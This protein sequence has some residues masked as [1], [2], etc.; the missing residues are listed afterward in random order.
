MKVMVVDDEP[1]IRSILEKM[2][3][4]QEGFNVVSS[5]GTFAE[6][7]ADYTKYHPEIVFMDIDLA[8]ANGLECAKVMTELNPKVRIIFATAHSEYMAN[9]FEIYAFDY[10]VK[11]FNLERV[12]K[13]LLRIKSME[14][15]GLFSHEHV[16]SAGEVPHMEGS[17]RASKSAELHKDKLL[18]KG[19]D[20]LF[21]IDI[22][23]IIMIERIGG[24]THIITSGETYKTSVALGSIEEKLDASEFIRCHKSYIIKLS[25]ISQIEVYGRWTY[26]VKLKNTSCTALMT[27][28]KYEEVRK[29]YE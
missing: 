19:R 26:T 12:Q 13:T 4:K 9:A 1:A 10:L 3:E 5:C 8:G 23:D 14:E 7:V 22:K 18:I 24:A 29:R 20:Q 6:A 17:D 28:Q 15:Q 27:A 25:E 11:P 16:I 2:V 21:F